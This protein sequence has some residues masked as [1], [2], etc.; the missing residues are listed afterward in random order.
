MDEEL[1]CNDG[2]APARFTN[3]NRVLFGHV[4]FAICRPFLL[5]CGTFTVTFDA[6]ED[7]QNVCNDCSAKW[8]TFTSSEGERATENLPPR[9]RAHNR[10][11]DRA[12]LKWMEN[13]RRGKWFGT[14]AGFWIVSQC[15]VRLWRFNFSLLLRCAGW[16]ATAVGAAAAHTWKKKNG[17]DIWYLRWWMHATSVGVVIPLKPSCCFLPLS[18][19]VTFVE[20]L[21]LRAFANHT[22]RVGVGQQQHTPIYEW[23]YLLIMFF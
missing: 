5:W 15:V 4:Q 7:H 8:S 1:R 14:A 22:R 12:E 16:L 9:Q 21:R 3:N 17:V 2:T 13:V 19:F 10:M 23:M 20:S 11:N 18:S 6:D